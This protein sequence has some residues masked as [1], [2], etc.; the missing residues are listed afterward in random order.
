VGV[1][2]LSTRLFAIWIR[3]QL[4][5]RS[6]HELID[7]SWLA[8][9]VELQDRL[10]IQ[11]KVALFKAAALESP[12]VIGWWRPVILFP[13]SALSGLTPAQLDAILIHELSHIRRHDYLVNLLQSSIEIV[14]FYH[15]AVWWVSNYIRQERENCCGDI[16][17]Q[18]SGDRFDYARALTTLEHLRIEGTGLAISANGGSIGQRIRRIIGAPAA[19]RFNTTWVGGI[20]G[21]AALVGSLFLSKG[22]LFAAG[23]AKANQRV[24]TTNSVNSSLP[25]VLGADLK[26]DNQ[27][28]LQEYPIDWPLVRSN[29]R[30]FVTDSADRPLA[31]KLVEYF[32][33]RRIRVKLEENIESLSDDAHSDEIC[34]PSKINEL[35]P[36]FRVRITH[37]KMA[38]FEESLRRLTASF[39]RIQIVVKW[40]E[41]QND[42]LPTNGLRGLLS[43]IADPSDRVSAEP[44]SLAEWNFKP[45]SGS[46]VA[47]QVVGNNK[48]QTNSIAV[49]E[50]VSSAVVL[51]HKQFT[52]FVYVLEHRGGVDLLT[53]PVLTTVSG[54]QAR[55]SD[56][57][58]LTIITGNETNSSGAV[59]PIPAQMSFGP[60]ADFFPELSSDKSRIQ[61]KVTERSREFV[62]YWE[63]KA[64]G[65]FAPIA[66]T[67]ARVSIPRP[68]FVERFYEA[69]DSLRNG[70]TLLV[71]GLTTES[72]IKTKDQI[73]VLG[74][75]PL[76][77]RLFRSESTAKRWKS[78]LI[79]VTPTLVNSYGD[80]AR[81]E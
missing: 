62:G 64:A 60:I 10:G 19:E 9:L 70:Q 80:R 31:A 44:F 37:S 76:L 39:D 28:L 30:N 51:S 24:Q 33:S 49:K 40:V 15:P 55:I 61:L 74:D 66:V 4:L 21:L 65:E 58:M 68:R 46:A 52:N 67:G 25:T 69:S 11:R 5:R 16:A 36:T 35:E 2:F 77:G 43:T 14:L 50:G 6:R 8:K 20:F 54:R 42:A 71:G 41:L 26:P 22:I 48:F 73:P 56:E 34:I 57:N 72:Q 13:A 17:I 29:L 79:M 3:V 78:P 1:F 53:G 7:E 81:I 23:D 63:T 38:L 27:R 12:A 59:I 18:V 45:C 47:I 75:I 32:A